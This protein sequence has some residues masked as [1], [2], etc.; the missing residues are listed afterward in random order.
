MS[1]MSQCLK[2]GPPRIPKTPRLRCLR[3][4]SVSRGVRPEASRLRV[5]DVSDV[6]VS[7]GGS[8]SNPQDS[9]SQMSQM[10]QCLKGGPP[11]IL[12]TPCLRCLRCLSVSRQSAPDP[13]KTQCLRC[14]RCLS[15]SRGGSAPDPLK[16]QCLRCLA[17]LA[18]LAR[19]LWGFEPR[20]SQMS[21]LSRL[22]RGAPLR[23]RTES[24]RGVLQ[25]SEAGDRQP[26]KIS[27]VSL[28]SRRSFLKSGGRRPTARRACLTC[29]ACLAGGLRG[30]GGRGQTTHQACLSCLTCLRGVRPLGRGLARGFTQKCRQYFFAIFPCFVGLILLDFFFSWLEL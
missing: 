14:L 24:S 15:V 21:R 19:L 18:C 20:A 23:V 25:R 4:L 10:S 7:Q 30:P 29:L 8:A 28:V 2:G 9:V 3:C 16:T 27:V 5:S 1:Q 17:C 13:L 6:S 22:S 11:R 12:K 26:A